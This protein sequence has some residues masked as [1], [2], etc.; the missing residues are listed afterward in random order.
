MLQDPE[1]TWIERTGYPS[2]MQNQRYDNSTDYL[3]DQSLDEE[4]YDEDAAY[5]ARRDEQFDD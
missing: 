1:V 4:D 2:W 3:I 5:E